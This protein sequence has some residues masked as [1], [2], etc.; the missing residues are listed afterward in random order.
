M[1]NEYE[2]KCEKE[3]CDVMVSVSKEM[4]EAYHNGDYN[5]F[6]CGNHKGKLTENREILQDEIDNWEGTSYNWK[7]KDS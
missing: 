6:I 7:N 2:I 3:D 5:S 1:S 4:Y